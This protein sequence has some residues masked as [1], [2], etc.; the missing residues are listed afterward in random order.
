MIIRAILL[1]FSAEVE[2]DRFIQIPGISG[3]PDR[4]QMQVWIKH[5]DRVFGQWRLNE[6]RIRALTGKF[7]RCRDFQI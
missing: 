5:N 3:L 4:L 2:I 1:I 6:A 7:I